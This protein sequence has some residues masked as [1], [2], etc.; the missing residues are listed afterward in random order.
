LSDIGLDLSGVIA[1]IVF[2][3]SA[4]GLGICGLICGLVAIARGHGTSGGILAQ[5]AFGYFAFAMALVVVN[6]IGFGVLLAV[7]DDIDKAL[8]ALFD[9]IALYAWLPVQPVL[10]L[11]SAILF[12]RSRRK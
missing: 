3:A 4:A 12:N 5:P 10:W 9:S 11:A 2:L 8:G 7:V 1:L 6:L